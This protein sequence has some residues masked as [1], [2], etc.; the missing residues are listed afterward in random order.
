MCHDKFTAKYWFV[1]FLLNFCELPF[2]SRGGMLEWL[3]RAGA[4][5]KGESPREKEIEWKETKS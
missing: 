4:P 5:E 1:A 2:F 3:L